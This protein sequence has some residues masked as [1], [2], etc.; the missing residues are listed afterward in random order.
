MQIITR[1]RT[2]QSLGL[3]R[4]RPTSMRWHYAGALIGAISASVLLWAAT[5]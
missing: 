4:R 2:G 5:R 1:A 3:N